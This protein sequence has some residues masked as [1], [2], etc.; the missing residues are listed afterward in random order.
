MTPAR[1]IR[2]RTAIALGSLVAA[3]AIGVGLA[4]LASGPAS[5]RGPR[6]APAS[7]HRASGGRNRTLS[8]HDRALPGQ[9]P[10]FRG[11]A[12]AP[13]PAGWHQLA[14]PDG[15]AVLSYPPNLRPVTGDTDAVSVAEVSPT[16]QYLLY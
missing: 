12:P 2:R 7:P 3:V 15:R 4:G 6:P 16:G 13:A 14:L 1:A 9:H 5:P 11:L 10:A 8:G